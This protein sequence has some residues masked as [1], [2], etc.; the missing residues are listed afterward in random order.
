MDKNAVT[1]HL[2][3]RFTLLTNITQISHITLRKP[4]II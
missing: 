1:I 4:C 3:Q 2:L